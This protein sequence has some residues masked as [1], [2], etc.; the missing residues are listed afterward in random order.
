MKAA[1]I[2]RYGEASVV[3]VT[4]DLPRPL[5]G[6]GKV[7]VEVH[8]A[9]L[10]PVDSFIRLGYMHKMMPLQF[11][12]TLGIDF[13]GV[14][15]EDDP[16]VG[17]LKSGDRVF[18]TASVMAGG[19]GAF[20]EYASVPAGLLA[21][22]PAALSFLEAAA[23][24]LAGVSALQALETMKLSKGSAI[25][26][27]GGAGGIG[28]FAI[29]MAKQLG[30]RVIA[31][32]RGSAVDYVRSLGADRIIDFEKTAVLASFRDCD[33]VFD[34]VG[35]DAYKGVLAVLRKGGIIVSMSAQPDTE[36]AAKLG[37]TALRQMTEIT[38]A[39]LDRLAQLVAEGAV[40]VHL[41]RVFP[42]EMVQDAFRAR[43]AGH[44]KGKL[45]LRI[46]E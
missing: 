21:K 22:A 2:S 37:V 23:L 46:R 14:V 32:C 20:A 42:L 11:P 28:T 41:D 10:N 8:A 40:K 34:T 45:V 43:E 36:L 18:G 26:I 27:Q 24:P 5:G 13:A 4:Q 31:S 35:G 6:D 39:R 38:T 44:M 3:E 1:Q 25:L 33:A 19:S 12:A 17:T 29:Q 30:A 7:L 16:K 9:S 15:V